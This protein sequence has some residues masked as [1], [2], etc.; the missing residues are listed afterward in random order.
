MNV[1]G[2]GLFLAEEVVNPGLDVCTEVG[3]GEAGAFERFSFC[4]VPAALWQPSHLNLSREKSEYSTWES[5]LRI[6]QAL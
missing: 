4:F 3:A 6:K 2:L 5:V 1:P